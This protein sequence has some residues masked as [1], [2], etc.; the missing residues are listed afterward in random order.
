MILTEQRLRMFKKHLGGQVARVVE[1]QGKGVGKE[2]K[3]V[4]GKEQISP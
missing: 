1:F 2:M 4:M 3:E